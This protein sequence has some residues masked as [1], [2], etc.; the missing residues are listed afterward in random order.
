M[1]NRQGVPVR[2][3]LN[4]I[5]FLILRLNRG[6]SLE[7]AIEEV[8]N[9]K[10][11]P[12]MKIGLDMTNLPFSLE[13]D[14]LEKYYYDSDYYCFVL[15]EGLRVMRT[16]SWESFDV[17]DVLIIFRNWIEYNTHENELNQENVFGF[18]EKN[19]PGALG[20]RT[21]EILF[22]TLQGLRRL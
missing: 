15:F 19:K 18:R 12:G 11:P 17:C 14:Q 21:Q 2:Y 1:S 6:I 8:S 22:D 7:I 20:K 9:M 16:S 5:D 13:L 3:V 10:Y 4:I